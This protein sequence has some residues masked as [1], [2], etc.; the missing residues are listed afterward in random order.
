MLKPLASVAGFAASQCLQDG[1][2]AD[3]GVSAS[4]IRQGAVKV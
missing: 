4:R 1:S 3:W 2:I